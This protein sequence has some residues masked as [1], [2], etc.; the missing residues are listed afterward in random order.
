MSFAGGVSW[1]KVNIGSFQ[2][3]KLGLD[4]GVLSLGMFLSSKDVYDFCYV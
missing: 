3:V 4:G 1:W 2:S